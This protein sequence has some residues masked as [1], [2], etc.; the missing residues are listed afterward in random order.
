MRA[1]FSKISLILFFVLFSNLGYAYNYTTSTITGACSDLSKSESWTTTT[2]SDLQGHI[3]SMSGIDCAG[4]PWAKNFIITSQTG[5]QSDST[6][7]SW[8]QSFN[9]K[10]LNLEVTGVCKYRIINVQ[11]G[12]WV[13]EDIHITEI[14]VPVPVDIS[15][16]NHGLYAV[17]TFSNSVPVNFLQF[18][19]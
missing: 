3:V 19:K 2:V 17:I 18:I 13:S 9:S 12:E 1:L 7:R 10:T 14:N 16:L 11:T 15:G 6:F 8:I 4:N 5:I